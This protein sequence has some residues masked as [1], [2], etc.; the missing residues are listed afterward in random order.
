MTLSTGTLRQV[1]WG[2][3]SVIP[4]GQEALSPLLGAGPLRERP[5]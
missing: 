5:L 3:C 4:G 1:A 2:A